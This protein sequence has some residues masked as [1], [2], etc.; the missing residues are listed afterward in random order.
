MAALLCQSVG[1]YVFLS[2]RR[3]AASTRLDPLLVS[4]VSF[5]SHSHKR[6]LLLFL[7]VVF[8]PL[9]AVPRSVG[10]LA[11]RPAGPAAPSCAKA[12]VVY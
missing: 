2:A 12:S 11:V 9:A 7:F 10:A 3:A 6:L 1:S 8:L 5:V 4:L